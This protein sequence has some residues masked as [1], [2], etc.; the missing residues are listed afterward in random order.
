[1]ECHGVCARKL[2]MTMAAGEFCKLRVNPRR[3]RSKRHHAQRSRAYF[4][5]I[6]ATRM[7]PIRPVTAAIRNMN[8]G[9]QSIVKTKMYV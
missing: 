1:M 8:S 2:H 4:V 3:D 7:A 9:Y 6:K 5:L